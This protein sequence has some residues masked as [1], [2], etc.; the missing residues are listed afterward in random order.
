MEL[1]G[2]HL[3][4]NADCH[5]QT[6]IETNHMAAPFITVNR[7]NTSTTATHALRLL[8]LQIQTRDLI[9]SLEEFIAESFQMFDGT[10]SEAVQFALNATK[11]G[12]STPAEAHAIFDLL[13]GTL[14]AL[15]GEAQNA[16]AVALATK[17]G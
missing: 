7:S 4:R 11:Y 10:D 13:N 2:E 3:G 16:Q 12:V 1:D 17:V 14:S 9:S 6:R 15:K 8:A 5:F